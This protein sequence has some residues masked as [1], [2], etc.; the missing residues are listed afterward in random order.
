VQCEERERLNR[1][2]LDAVAKIQESGSAVLDITSAKWKEATSQTRAT[3]KAALA[4]LKR[5]E[6]EHGC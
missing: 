3:S 5:H 6:E 4:E 2:Y 1:I